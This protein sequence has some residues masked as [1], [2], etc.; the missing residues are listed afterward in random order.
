MFSDDIDSVIDIEEERS[1]V[2]I[3]TTPFGS[4][5]RAL[6]AYS[7][8]KLIT[9]RHGTTGMLHHFVVEPDPD[10]P[11][12]AVFRV[13]RTPPDNAIARVHRYTDIIVFKAVALSLIDAGWT[14]ASV[15]DIQ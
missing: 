15:T 6:E 5:A 10:G 11:V 1:V 4:I 8:P 2:E 9:L 7:V 3:D 12:A 13:R 14:L